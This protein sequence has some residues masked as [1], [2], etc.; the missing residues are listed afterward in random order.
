MVQMVG[1]DGNPHTLT[2]EASSLFDA[3]DKAI[4]A[5]AKLW[6]FDPTAS[7]TVQSCEDRWTVK[8]ERVRAWRSGSK[9]NPL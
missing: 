7:L 9:R 6:W 4:R 8:Q 3:A 5:W 1:K 2:L